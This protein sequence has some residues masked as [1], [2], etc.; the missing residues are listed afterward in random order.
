MSKFNW[1]LVAVCLGLIAFWIG[2]G[3]LI[4]TKF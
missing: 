3:A 1:P 2:V 4:A